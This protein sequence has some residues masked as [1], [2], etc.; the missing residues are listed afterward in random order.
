MSSLF[1]AFPSWHGG[2]WGVGEGMAAAW[3]V[4]N[5]S[6]ARALPREK[7]SF[8]LLFFLSHYKQNNQW[9]RLCTTCDA[10]RSIVKTF[11]TLNSSGPSHIKSSHVSHDA[12]LVMPCDGTTTDCFNISNDR[13]NCSNA[14]TWKNASEQSERTILFLYLEN[15]EE[16]I[17]CES[18]SWQPVWKGANG[19]GSQ[20]ASS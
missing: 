14:R 12:F 20:G 8:A 7:M 19:Y 16:I 2:V 5:Q 17:L 11:L 3:L 13:S 15:G 10:S 1:L 18:S 6:L 4:P 9:I